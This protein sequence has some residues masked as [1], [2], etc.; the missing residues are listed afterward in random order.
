MPTQLSDSEFPSVYEEQEY[1]ATVP[2]CEYR[3]LVPCLASIHGS[4]R[5]RSRPGEGPGEQKYAKVKDA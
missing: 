5:T 2:G 4:D 1:D 3:P